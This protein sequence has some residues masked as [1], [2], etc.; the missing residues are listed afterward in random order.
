[1]TIRANQYIKTAF[2]IEDANTLEKEISNAKDANDEIII[3][4]TNIKFFTTL[5]FNNSIC[6]HVLELGPEL[7]NKKYKIINI[8]DVG[9]ST[10]DHSYE[11]AVEYYKLSPEDREVQSEI[12]E[13][14][15]M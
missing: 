4:F 3:D 11:N 8:S 13:S 7:F 5:F 9:K 12:V 1:M 15:E 6:K 14:D 2:S 10:Y